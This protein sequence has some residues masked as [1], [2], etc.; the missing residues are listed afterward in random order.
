MRFLKI[1]DPMHRCTMGH[2]YFRHMSEIYKQVKPNGPLTV[3]TP[4]QLNQSLAEPAQEVE[5]QRFVPE[6]NLTTC[7]P[8]LVLKNWANA[9][10]NLSPASQDILL[11]KLTQL[12]AKYAEEANVTWV[13]P[14]PP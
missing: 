9:V 6:I 8:G 10:G 7:S 13:Y 3:R 4:Q 2:K 12:F 11:G 14:A 1:T 5:P